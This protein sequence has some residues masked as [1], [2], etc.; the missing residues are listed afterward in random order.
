VLKAE[1]KG[2]CLLQ[3]Y[4]DSEMAQEYKRLADAVA[5]KTLACSGA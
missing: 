1:E 5:A 2:Q 3:A 4:S